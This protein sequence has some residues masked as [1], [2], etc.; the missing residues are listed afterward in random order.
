MTPKCNEIRRQSRQGSVTFLPSL[1]PP[2][3]LSTLPLDY[4]TTYT[5]LLHPHPY[6]TKEI[7]RAILLYSC[8]KALVML[9]V[10][11]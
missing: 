7:R 1:A 8:P 3:L 10:I 5:S 4:L 9:L 6:S 11:R 2:N